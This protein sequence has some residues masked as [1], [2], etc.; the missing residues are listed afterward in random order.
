MWA[1]L[2]ELEDPLLKSLASR[3]PM[4][5]LKGRADKTTVKYLYAYGRWR[6]W[7]DEHR[8]PQG[9]PVSE[10]HLVLYM[11]YLGDSVGSKSAVETAVN[12]I[13]WVHELAGYPPISSVPIVVA[14]L[15]GLQRLLA[16]PITKKEPITSTMLQAMVASMPKT[17][18][19]SDIRLAAVA[20]MAYAAFLRYDE[21]SKLRCC[22]VE[23]C[24][25]HMMVHIVSS[26]TDQYREG[27]R[28]TV[29]RTGLP[30]CPVAMMERYFSLAE[31]QHSSKE[32]LFRGITVTKAGE[33]LRQSGSLSYTRLREL[34]LRKLQELGYDKRAFSLHSLRAGGAS[35]AA[36]AGVKDRLFKRHGR[37]RSE[38]AKD[39]YVKDSLQSRLS[40]SKSIGL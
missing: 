20:L 18:L 15:K 25:D 6:R 1:K 32:R 16:K 30:T 36:N 4:T 17:P 21:L 12:C 9:L 3:L 35:A 8:V 26:K 37:W 7:A 14:T 13:A 10:I 2:R 19:L 22:D 11:Q 34:L 29:A 5:V 24:A 38:T 23:F 39:G 31:L 28:L 27:A 33:R 40:V